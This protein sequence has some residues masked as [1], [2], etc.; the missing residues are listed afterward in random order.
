MKK[1]ERL[2]K[3]L[4]HS[5][6]GSRREIKELVRLGQVSVN[7][8]RIKDS[9]VQVNPATDEILVN[10]EAAV[11]REYVYLML[12]KPPGVVSATEDKKERTVIDLLGSGFDH[13]E[14]FPVGRLD[15]D[16]EGLLLL[17]N[18]GK[19]T[20]QLLSPRKHVPKTYYADVEGTVTEEDIAQF[21]RGIELDDGYVTLPA[22]LTII[23][24]GEPNL[25]ILSQIQVTIHEGKFHQ[26]KRMF[27]AVGKNVV[28]LKRLSMGSLKL[29]DDL[30]IGEY[31]ELSTD[32]V[33]A[34]RNHEL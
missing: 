18:D 3:V 26:I 34:L 13:L 25:G 19:L 24:R 5:G 11:Y 1:T 33:E 30:P 9:G 21:L 27:L 29:D 16:T 4:G 14:L 17:T 10:G 15:K 31:R 8:K 22:E 20:H 2:D 12:H 32:E 6:F 23:L 28:Y 7:A